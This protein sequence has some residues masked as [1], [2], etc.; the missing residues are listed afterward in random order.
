MINCDYAK[1][2]EDFPHCIHI[3]A[4]T[5][6]LTEVDAVHC[7]TPDLDFEGKVLLC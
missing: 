6:I 3:I 2:S 5:H 4:V 7:I 1:F